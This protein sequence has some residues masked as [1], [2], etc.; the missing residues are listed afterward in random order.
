MRCNRVKNF[1]LG[2]REL[3]GSI[4]S[5]STYRFEYVLEIG[6]VFSITSSGVQVDCESFKIFL[7]C[8]ILRQNQF[9]LYCLHAVKLTWENRAKESTCCLMTELVALCLLIEVHFEAEDQSFDLLNNALQAASAYDMN[10]VI[11]HH[12]Y[13]SF[14]IQ[15]VDFIGAIWQPTSFEGP[16]RFLL[17]P[18]LVFSP[19]STFDVQACGFNRFLAIDV[20]SEHSSVPIVH[21]NHATQFM[22]EREF[23]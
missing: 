2:L 10:R 22:F 12:R 20:E 9:I 18:C 17:I 15:S 16:I 5:L 7:N 6:L 19:R 21:A 23:R 13:T 4:H 3:L 8:R 1:Q 11:I 14:Q